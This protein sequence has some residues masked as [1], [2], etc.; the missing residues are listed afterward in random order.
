[1]TTLTKAPAAA[2]WAASAAAIAAAAIAAAAIAAA[3]ATSAA[4]LGGHHHQR[5]G[6]RSRGRHAPRVCGRG[7]ACAHVSAGY[8]PAC[9][10]ASRQRGANQRRRGPGSV[11]RGPPPRLR[12]GELLV[13]VR[14]RARARG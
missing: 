11:P 4:A 5:T 6:H 14:V 2:A 12:L 1:M 13:R 3:A 7:V 10:H 8:H 9:G